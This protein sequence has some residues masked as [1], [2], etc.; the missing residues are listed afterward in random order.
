[1][2][3]RERE[4]E[5]EREKERKRKKKERKRE[6]EK[7]RKKERAREREKERKENL[8]MIAF[9]DGVYCIQYTYYYILASPGIIFTAAA[10]PFITL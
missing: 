7:E 8:P 10:P 1:M 2:R 3:K 4:R 5:R 6:R 9:D